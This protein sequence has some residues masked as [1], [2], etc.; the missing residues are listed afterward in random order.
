MKV[1]VEL[2]AKPGRRANLQRFLECLIYIRLS[3]QPGLASSAE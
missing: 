3:R 1:I 2:H